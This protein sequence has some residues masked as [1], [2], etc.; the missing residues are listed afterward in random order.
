MQ[1]KTVELS[2]FMW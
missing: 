1:C 2:A